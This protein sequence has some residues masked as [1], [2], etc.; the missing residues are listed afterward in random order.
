[1]TSVKFTMKW[2]RCFFTTGEVACCGRAINTIEPD[3]SMGFTIETA[4]DT[5]EILIIS[6]WGSKHTENPVYW[7][8]KKRNGFS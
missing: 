7:N 3:N 8:L 6:L 4:Y 1:M 2:K 5:L